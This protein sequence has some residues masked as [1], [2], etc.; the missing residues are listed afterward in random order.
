MYV[1]YEIG[2]FQGIVGDPQS[3]HNLADSLHTLTLEI[4]YYLW[5]S[6][7]DLNHSGEVCEDLSNNW[8]LKRNRDER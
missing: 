1:V 6:Q 8:L 2:S 3:Y 7:V 4:G 5:N